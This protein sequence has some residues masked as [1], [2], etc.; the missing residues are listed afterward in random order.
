[1]RNNQPPNIT[2]VPNLVHLT[3][4]D[5]T[6]CGL[7]SLVFVL[8]VFFAFFPARRDC[9]NEQF[10]NETEKIKKKKPTTKMRSTSAI[11]FF[12][13]LPGIGILNP[14]MS[15][16]FCLKPQPHFAGKE[17]HTQ[18]C[19]CCLHHKPCQTQNLQV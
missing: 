10:I 5:M 13:E 7:P 2:H 14:T 6:A 19:T 9:S 18:N 11:Q 4:P 17:T 3:S 16:G 12:P 1:M 15:D 8:E